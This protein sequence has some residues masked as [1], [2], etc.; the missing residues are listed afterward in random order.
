MA[1][2][3]APPTVDPPM[4]S[5]LFLAERVWR[6]RR[7]VLGALAVLAR[8]TVRVGARRTTV[9][10]AGAAGPV[11]YCTVGTA[12]VAV[13]ANAVAPNG[14][15]APFATAGTE[16]AAGWA[17]FTEDEPEKYDVA[18]APP[19]NANSATAAAPMLVLIPT[20]SGTATLTA[21]TTGSRW[22]Y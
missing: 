3:P 13:G 16:A 15:A 17:A 21:P 8:D 7:G 19:A 10:V 20:S 9:R 18:S 12:G 11:M 4:M 14:A 2:M 1:P 22:E 6:T 5:A